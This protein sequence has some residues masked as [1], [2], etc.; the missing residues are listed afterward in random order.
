MAMNP[1]NIPIIGPWLG[2]LTKINK[3]AAMPCMVNPALLV[4]GVFSQT[5]RLVWGIN[6][7]DCK[8]SAY[9]RGA[10]P[11][12][13]RPHGGPGRTNPGRTIRGQFG[14]DHITNPVNVAPLNRVGNWLFAGSEFAQRAGLYMIL[15]DGYLDTMY[16]GAS[17]AMQWSGCPNPNEP[18]AQAHISEQ[19]LLVTP[20]PAGWSTVI[21]WTTIGSREF[22]TGVS[23]WVPNHAAPFTISLTFHTSLDPLF[24]F[25]LPEYSVRVWDEG[26]QI[27]SDPDRPMTIQGSHQSVTSFIWKFI[28]VGVGPFRVQIAKS[29]GS[30]WLNYARVDIY[31]GPIDKIEATVCGAKIKKSPIDS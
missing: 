14:I 11:L 29:E 1:Q 31:G 22:T 27:G 10:R 17:L 24:P 7:P 30:L 23:G 16:H 13:R 18:Y 26:Q 4:A 15:I 19:R 5:P 21:G 9:E 2:K 6:G 12:R 28:V 25:P 8:D 3:L 20:G